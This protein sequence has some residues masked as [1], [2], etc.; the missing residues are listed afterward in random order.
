MTQRKPLVG[1]SVLCALV[2]CAVAAPSATAK[3][4][5][6]YTCKKVELGAAFSDEH[7][8]KDAEGGKG[9]I[10]E[11]IPEEESL[12]VSAVNVGP[13]KFKTVIAGLEVELEAGSFQTC[14]GGTTLIN[15]TDEETGQMFAGG[16]FCGEFTKVVV[17]KPAKCSVAGNAVKLNEGSWATGVTK[18]EPIEM[19][20]EW[21]AVEENP[22]AEFEITGTECILKKVM[23]KV[24]GFA[25]SNA[26]QGELPLDG[27]TVKF[28]TKD[29]EFNLKVGTQKAKFEGTFTP[30]DVKTERPLTLTTTE[31]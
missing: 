2:L 25:D 19:F 13:A 11:E 27:S 29:T 6:G 26:M 18:A 21:G 22:I 9:F 24:T 30:H 16:L 10:H 20:V 8:T 17:K 23:V 15:D 12:E 3:G 4:T 7:C 28:N 31:K 14:E 1:L 5:T